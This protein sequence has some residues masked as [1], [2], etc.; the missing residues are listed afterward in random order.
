MIASPGLRRQKVERMLSLL[1]PRQDDGIKVAVITLY[2]DCVRFGDPSDVQLLID[3]LRKAG[4]S[5][6]LTDSESEHFAVIDKKL[7][8][9]GGMNL[10]GKEDAWYNLIRVESVQAAAELLEMA[11]LQTE[12]DAV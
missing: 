1:K 12:R 5:V 9:H 4:V 3:E 2:P 6:S 10:L 11:K 8:W 7:V